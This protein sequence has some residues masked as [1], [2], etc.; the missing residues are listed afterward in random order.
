MKTILTAAAFAVA[1]LTATTASAYKVSDCSVISEASGAIVSARDKGLSANKVKTILLQSDFASDIKL[2]LM[3][4]TN[5]TFSNP[6]VTPEV[7]KLMT[8]KACVD[9]FS[10]GA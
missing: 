6:S 1:T 3:E 8:L 2:L 4:V 5:I 9:Q 10:V 7:M